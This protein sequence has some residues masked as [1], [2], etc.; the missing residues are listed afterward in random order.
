[1]RDAAGVKSFFLGAT[2]M[3]IVQSPDFVSFSEM[4]LL[5]A[6]TAQEKRPNLLVVC[7]NTSAA[8]AVEGLEAFCSG[9]IT[10][11][12]LPGLLHLP[13]RKRGTLLLH[14]VSELTLS[15]QIALFDWLGTRPA[16]LQVVSVTERSLLSLVLAGRFLEGLYYRLNTLCVVADSPVPFVSTEKAT[17]CSW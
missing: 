3:S 9:P 8:D 17:S 15:Q 14:D 7:N 12:R 5:R 16:E 1:M 13:S 4:P 10:S 6:L 11:C 2:D